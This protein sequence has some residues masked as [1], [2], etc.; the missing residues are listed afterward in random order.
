MWNEQKVSA[1][2]KICFFIAMRL[3]FDDR[4][5]RGEL[6]DEL[7]EPLD[8]PEVDEVPDFETSISLEESKT[9]F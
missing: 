7:P 6:E 3:K 8:I 4:V 1:R 5:G 2:K 9:H